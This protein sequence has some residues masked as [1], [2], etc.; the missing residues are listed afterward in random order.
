VEELLAK[1][2][3]SLRLKRGKRTIV[4]LGPYEGCVLVMFILGEKAVRPARECGL[5]ARAIQA[6]D[7]AERYPEGTGLRL[8]IKG[9][10]DIPAIK[11]LAGIK[12]EN[13]EQRR[14]R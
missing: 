3:W 8:L 11:K 5:P 12:I 7:Q 10:R 1:A 13:R 4:W 2:G 6:L 9:T 14:V